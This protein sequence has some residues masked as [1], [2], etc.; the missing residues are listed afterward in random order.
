MLLMLLLMLLLFVVVVVVVVVVLLLCQPVVKWTAHCLDRFTD[1]RDK[2]SLQEFG[3][4]SKHTEH[5]AT[6]LW[7]HRCRK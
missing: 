5:S 1:S 2:E 6:K 7:L 3:Q 4:H